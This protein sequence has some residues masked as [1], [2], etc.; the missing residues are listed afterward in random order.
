MKTKTTDVG[1]M[2][3]K[4]AT[5]FAARRFQFFMTNREVWRLQVLQAPQLSSKRQPSSK[6]TWGLRLQRVTTPIES[7]A[8]YGAYGAILRSH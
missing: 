6:E 7:Q 2:L 8:I 4:F 3:P 1:G 5:C